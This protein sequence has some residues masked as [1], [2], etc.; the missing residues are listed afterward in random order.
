M[1][2][3]TRNDFGKLCEKHKETGV[4]AE[5]GVQYGVFSKQIAQFYSGKIIC[6]DLWGDESIYAEAK[7]NLANADKFKLYRA[8]SL[9]I[10]E[11]V[12]DGTLDWV[13]IDANHHYRELLADIDAWYAKVRP[14]GIVAGHDYC[15]S[16][17]DIEV[18]Q[19]VDEWCAAHNY[20][21]TIVCGDSDY[22]NGKPYPT[23][24]FIKR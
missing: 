23:W 16:D 8:D 17:A 2:I 19:A 1:N 20:T 13:Y 11:F 6:V 18:I 9:T 4:G 22:Y 10:A 15:T 3:E 7:A 24:Y 21:P 14:C 12:P 5:I